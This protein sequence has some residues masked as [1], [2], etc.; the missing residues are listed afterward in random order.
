MRLQIECIPCVLNMSASMIRMINLSESR[1]RELFAGILQIPGLQGN[2]YDRTSPDIIESVMDRIIRASGV[3]DPFS[4]AKQK[5]NEIA[6]GL[7]PSLR[8]L[9]KESPDPLLTAVKLAIFG[10]AMD[11]MVPHSTEQMERSIRE[12]LQYPLPA[13]EYEKFQS[14]LS[15][16]KRLLILGDNA[17]EIVLDRLLIETLKQNCD[18]DIVYVV[19]SMPVMN[20]STVTEAQFTGMDKVA[21]VLENGIRGPFPGTR[22]RRCSTEVRGRIGK[23]DIIISKGG[24]NF[25]SL[26]EEKED[27]K[28]RITFLFLSKCAPY[29]RRFGVP[30]FQPIIASY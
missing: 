11:F 28:D 4:Q 21:M 18:P 24:G 17:G 6:L 9:V 26:D 30:P 3:R 5:Q 15:S 16:G 27:L 19:R 25:D 12:S 7:Y 23:A 10:N 20:D 8:S 22:I 13:D 14:R 2:S 1:S 29:H